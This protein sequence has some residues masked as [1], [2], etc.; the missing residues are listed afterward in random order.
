M[1]A[2]LDPGGPFEEDIGGFD[3]ATATAMQVRRLPRDLDGALDAL[4]AD[5]V[6]V[7]AF[8]SRLLSRLVDGRRVEAEDFRAQVTP[9][10]VE[11]YVDEA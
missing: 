1:D 8:D 3:P 2:G 4:L 6:L 9:W 5:D 7:D 11:H 10:E